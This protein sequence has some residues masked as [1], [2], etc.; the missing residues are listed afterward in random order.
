MRVALWPDDSAENHAAE[1]AAFL[2][3][4]LSGWLAGLDAVAAFVAERPGG[5]L[6]GFLEASVRPMADGCTTHPVGYVEGWFVDDEM[7]RQGV[8]K[9]LL[10][11]AEGWAES[12]GCREMAS[13]AHLDNA[14]SL[15]AHQAAGFRAETPCVRFHKVLPVGG[16]AR[17]EK[18]Q[19]RLEV[20]EGTFAVCR[21]A[22]DAA[23]PGW[24]EGGEFLSFSRTAEE[25]SVVCLQEAVPDGV[26]CERGWRCLRAVGPLDFALTGVL[27]ALVVP[28]ARAGVA[29]FAVST[30]DTD[31]LLVKDGDLP[32]AV[33]AL[34]EAGHRI[35]AP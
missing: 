9:A 28:L 29:V 27:A 7:R 3:G 24:A 10:A 2:S 33:R 32:R 23:L 11:V 20:L 17:Q 5:G 35:E 14:V 16:T 18:H 31:Y 19:L 25:L 13:D 6:C 26:R 1:I 22:D 8:G 12:R 30:F 21:L 15:A 34:A 4:N